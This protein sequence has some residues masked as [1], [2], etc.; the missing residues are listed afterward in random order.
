MGFF[1]GE[2]VVWLLM[3]LREE[4]RGETGFRFGS[5]FYNK[6]YLGVVPGVGVKEGI[7]VWQGRHLV[8][9][10]EGDKSLVREIEAE[11]G[12]ERGFIDGAGVFQRS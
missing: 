4:R 3:G 8:F 1:S 2:E 11:E 12:Q 6:G 10:G 5:R 9:F 7:L